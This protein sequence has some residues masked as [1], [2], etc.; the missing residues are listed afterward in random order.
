MRLPLISSGSMGRE[1]MIIGPYPS[2]MLDPL[3]IRTYLSATYG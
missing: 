1:A 2:P 3:A